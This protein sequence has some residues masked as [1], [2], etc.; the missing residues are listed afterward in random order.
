MWKVLLVDDDMIVRVGIKMM[1]T[2]K[3]NNFEVVAEAS[4]GKQAASLFEMYSPD[5]VLADIMMPGM[6]GLELLRVIRDKNQDTRVIML[7]NYDDKE[8]IKEA[9][10]LGA[11]DFV[12]KSDMDSE[13]LNRLLAKENI[14]LSQRKYK[15]TRVEDVN[16][17]TRKRLLLQ[18]VGK[19]YSDPVDLN[20]FVQNVLALKSEGSFSMA[21]LKI[22]YDLG[23][24]KFDVDY[25]IELISGVVSNHSE[26]LAVS[27][28]KLKTIYVLMM[29]LS[30]A[31]T[32]NTLHYASQDIDSALM[33]YSKI[34]VAT[35]ISAIHTNVHNLEVMVDEAESASICA[36]KRTQTDVV[37]Y[38]DI[39][40]H[41]GS[42]NGI[43]KYIHA[44]YAE[45]ITLEDVAKHAYVSKNY[46]SA[47]FS[48]VM[49]VS[50]VSYLTQYR[51]NRAV[52]LLLMTNLRVM[53]IA[54]AVGFITDRYFSQTFK[55]YVG[56]TP[57][58][59][60]KE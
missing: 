20:M 8:Y 46:L 23:Q 25:L 16:E 34:R 33:L 42:I 39:E 56:V 31:L 57:T 24:L 12:V 51:M 41:R 11:S 48:D 55:K 9:L 36:L 58:E 29:R 14:S 5:L 59:F 19:V 21:L 7:T 18:L 17:A 10:R 37:F 2:W 49:K 47:L 1:G 44:H 15:H 28:R 60:R 38:K 35:G 6:D 54:Q 53:E 3:E 27:N 30:G 4:S 40:G 26:F 43:L 52:E 32:E 45:Q 22:S 13:Y 50:F